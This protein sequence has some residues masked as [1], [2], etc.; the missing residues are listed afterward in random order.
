[1]VLG[2]RKHGHLVR[3][4]G[5]GHNLLVDPPL[6]GRPVAVDRAVGGLGH[7]RIGNPV[8]FGDCIGLDLPDHVDQAVEHL[9]VLP[10]GLQEQLRV[11]DADD[12]GGLG[13]RHRLLGGRHG[14][15][16]L[17]AAK[18]GVDDQP[19]LTVGQRRNQQLPIGL[20]RPLD[21]RTNQFHHLLELLLLFGVHPRNGKLLDVAPGHLDPFDQQVVV[22]G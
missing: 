7:L 3:Q 1:M 8:V 10:A 12:D 4:A 20:V 2:D 5:V 21:Q 11:A 18:L 19:G 16:K 9:A 17:L 22:L 14:P 15:E 13:H 6:F